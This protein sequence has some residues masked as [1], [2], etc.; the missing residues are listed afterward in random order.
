MTSAAVPNLKVLSDVSILTILLQVSSIVKN[1]IG[2][3]SIQSYV[4]TQEMVSL[5][6]PR[7]S[8]TSKDSKAAFESL[9]CVTDILVQA[10]QVV[11]ASYDNASESS[12]T[13][14]VP[15]PNSESDAAD[16]DIPP[17]ESVVSATTFMPLNATV[18][19]N[20]NDRKS[21]NGPSI[22]PLGDIREIE[23]GKCLW[24]V[25]DPLRDVIK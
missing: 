9:N 20:P 11:A 21:L 17:H 15:S 4:E 25:N 13:L 7:T 16:F 23:G 2:D 10:T 18:V 14:V 19:P 6:T 12:F 5:D 24:I 1:Q 8:H 22:G 3:P